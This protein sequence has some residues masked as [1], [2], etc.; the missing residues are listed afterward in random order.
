MILVVRYNQHI[1]DEFMNYIKLQTYNK[2]LIHFFVNK[3]H[4][5]IHLFTH[6]KV[7]KIDIEYIIRIISFISTFAKSNCSTR[8]DIYI[9][10]TP[11][12]K[13]ITTFDKEVSRTNINSAYTFACSA[14]NYIY[15]Y[16]NEEWKKTLIHECIHAFGVDFANIEF[17]NSNSI[18]KKID[19]IF[20][21]GINYR[22]NEAY[23]ETIAVLINIIHLF[24]NQNKENDIIPFVETRLVHETI[25]SLIQSNKLLKHS[26]LSMRNLLF[27]KDNT[28]YAESTSAFSYYFIKSLFLYNFN[29]FLSVTQSINNY[30][31]KSKFNN[32]NIDKYINL[33]DKTV[34]T[35]NFKRDMKLAEKLIT[36]C[37]LLNKSMKFSF[38][39]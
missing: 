31:L 24:S 29:S 21:L 17:D 4:I 28:N 9:F 30:S 16:R 18:N 25:H 23:C 6:K 11:F 36:Q 32:K 5:Y 2:K 1:P 38:Y 33:I 35:G 34:Q 27:G 3:R 19:S 26:S 13:E 39:G 20:H 10:D 7:S 14:N 37:P 8:L 15:I 22:M 12:K